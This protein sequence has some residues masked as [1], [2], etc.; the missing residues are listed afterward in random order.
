M[1]C[2]QDCNIMHDHIGGIVERML[3]TAWFEFFFC[4]DHVFLDSWLELGSIVYT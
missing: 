1:V 3:S 4:E 2:M